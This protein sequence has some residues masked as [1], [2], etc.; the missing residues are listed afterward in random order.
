MTDTSERDQQPQETASRFSRRGLLVAAVGAAGLAIGSGGSAAAFELRRPGTRTIVAPSP[1]TTAPASAPAAP[2]P[3][4]QFRSRPDL[5]PPRVQMTL[6]GTPTTEMFLFTPNFGPGATGTGQQGLM[7]LNGRGELTWFQP[8]QPA[9]ANL[10]VQTYQGQP[11]LTWWQGSFSAA[12]FGQGT[13]VIADTH[14]VQIAAVNGANGLAAD[15]H[16]FVLTPQGTALITAYG[17]GTADLGA[18]GGAAAA[19]IYFGVAQ[20]IDIATG[21]LV[22]EW[23]SID[24]V[25]VDETYATIGT[26]PLDYFHINSIDIDPADGNLLVSARNTWTIYKINRTTG[27]VM[28]RLGGK[29]SDFSMGSG[30]PFAWQHDAR[31]Q[32]N[33]QLTLFDDSAAPAVAAES[34]ALLLAL[35][36][37]ARTATLTTAFAHPARLLSESQGNFQ[38]LADGGGIVGWG[39]EPYFSHFDLHGN[40]VRDGRMPTNMQSYRAFRSPWSAV[41]SGAPDI[42]TEGDSVGGAA[43]YVSWNGATEVRSWEVLTGDDPSSL[44]PSGSVPKGG[45]ETAITVHPNGK[46]VAVRG[47]DKNGTVLGTSKVVALSS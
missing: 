32:A 34:R 3:E 8:L 47:L 44:A 16:E 39:S 2:A 21:D 40:L 27:D 38:R 46:Y 23:R 6:T 35:D 31:A 22:F 9:F 18:L 45:F 1:T 33:G 15:L 17:Q 28:W 7:I 20:E 14:Y 36:T 29:H 42:A 26:G 37:T 24:H 25:P 43:V 19:P 10:R 41:P 11:V 4:L 13:G 5:S 12:G 30:T